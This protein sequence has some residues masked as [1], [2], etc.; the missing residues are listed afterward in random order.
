MMEINLFNDILTQTVN[1]YILGMG[2]DLS[3]SIKEDVRS[4]PITDLGSNR[5]SQ[6]S[7]ISKNSSREGSLSFEFNAAR[8]RDDPNAEPHSLI[9]NQLSTSSHRASSPNEWLKK[10]AIEILQR[11]VKNVGIELNLIET[12][13]KAKLK[14]MG[15]RD[16]QDRKRKVKNEL[17]FYDTS[18][19]SA[20]KRFPNRDEKEPMRPLYV[21]YKFLKQALDIK[22]PNANQYE[23]LVE[24]LA[25]LKNQRLELKEKLEAFQQ[26][27][28]QKNSRKIRFKQDIQ[29][30]EKEYNLYHKLKDEI[31]E[32]EEKIKN[33]PN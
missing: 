1:K 2:N 32:I 7:M 30:V 16:L 33:C 26:D 10:N 3:R 24:E 13:E 28:I 11:S 17:K 5:L 15:L 21:Y 18:F 6:S 12:Q 8:K 14:N 22:E 19:E 20:F 29:D 9:G 27:F 4:G 25:E 23:R 31:K